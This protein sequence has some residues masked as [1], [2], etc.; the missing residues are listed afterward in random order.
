MSE[1]NINIRDNQYITVMGWMRN[2]PEIK[3]NTELNAYALIYGFSQTKGQY[4]TCKQSYIASWLGITKPKCSEL[5][6]RMESK[7]LIRKVLVRCHGSVKQYKYCCNMPPITISKKETDDYPKGNGAISQKEMVTVSQ[8]EHVY[9]NNINNNLYISPQKNKN[10]SKNQF[11]EFMQQE[12]NIEQIEM[13]LLTNGIPELA[14]KDNKG[15][16]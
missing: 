7:G 3:T 5:L 12:Y 10:Q 8:T 15:G 13:D 9:N 14:I 2:I 16:D 11:N 4:L 1:A 6:K